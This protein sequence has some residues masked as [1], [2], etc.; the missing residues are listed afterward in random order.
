MLLRNQL[1]AGIVDVPEYDVRGKPG[2]FEPLIS[3]QL[4]YRVQAILSGRVPSTAPRKRAHSD[5]PLRGFVRCESCGRGLT[6]SW[7]KGNSSLRLE[8]PLREGAAGA[9]LEIALKTNGCGLVPERYDD[10]EVPW[11]ASGGVWATPIVVAGDP[12][13]HI[14]R[15][16]DVEAVARRGRFQDVHEA[17]VAN[18]IPTQGKHGTSGRHPQNALVSGGMGNVVAVVA[19]NLEG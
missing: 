9:G 6:G 16:P 17:F 5:F 18:H 11:A 13:S 4:F 19:K 8:M 12:R 2:D 15:E 1:Y 3:E 7:S 10:V 14:R